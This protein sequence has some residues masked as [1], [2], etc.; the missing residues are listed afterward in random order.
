MQPRSRG[1]LE[2]LSP[3][4]PTGYCRRFVLNVAIALTSDRYLTMISP[5]PLHQWSPQKRAG[6]RADYVEDKCTR[7]TRKG[8]GGIPRSHTTPSADGAYIHRYPGTSLQLQER[9]SERYAT[10]GGSQ[11][12]VLQE[13]TVHNLNNWATKANMP[14][15]LHARCVMT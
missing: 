5:A 15:L 2:R 10:F 9:K 14:P 8:E 4:T 12:F 13:G 3:F 7:V 6:A 1:S 11:F